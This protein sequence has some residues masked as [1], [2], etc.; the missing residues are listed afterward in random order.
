MR[1]VTLYRELF[2]KGNCRKLRIDLAKAEWGGFL[3][4]NNSKN[5]DMRWNK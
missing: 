5:I 4:T 2:N 1:E 3:H